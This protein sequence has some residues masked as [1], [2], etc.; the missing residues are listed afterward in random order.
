MEGVQVEDVEPSDHGAVQQHRAHA[1]EGAQRAREGDEPVR[2]V[3]PVDL[4]LA[5]AHGL[6]VAGQHDHDG[7]HRGC[8]VVPG[9]RPV[10]EREDARVGL[11]ERAPQC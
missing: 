10:V 9:E 2:R 4:D 5:D 3:A 6:D 8:P 7:R 11:R 1:V